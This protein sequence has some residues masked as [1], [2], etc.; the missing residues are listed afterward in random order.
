MTTERMPVLAEIGSGVTNTREQ[1]GRYFRPSWATRQGGGMRSHH[2]AGHTC[3]TC[4]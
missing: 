1:A 2:L 4:A 3:T